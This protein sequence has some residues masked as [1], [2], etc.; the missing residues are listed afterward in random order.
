MTGMRRWW[1][2][3][4]CLGCGTAAGL[5]AGY[6]AVTG[7]GPL[8]AAS[9][10]VIPRGNIAQIGRALRQAGVIARVLPFRLAAEATA[11]QGPLR[12]AEFR[13]PAEASLWDVLL[14]LRSGRPVQH[15]LTIPEGLT[16]AQIVLLFWQDAAL[17]GGIT[18]PKEGSVL[19]QTY[20]FERGATRQSVLGRAQAA[21][22][23][24]VVSAWRERAAEAGVAS[25]RDAII[26]ASIVERE[27]ALA[28]ERPLVARVFRNRLLHGMRLQSDP[29]TIYGASGGYGKL[30]RPLSRADLEADGPYN[31]Y[32]V[33]GLPAAPICNPG[34]ASLSAVLHPAPG[35][36]LYFV[37]D[38]KGGHSFATSL[39]EHEQNVKVYRAQPK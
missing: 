31:T 33:A 5:Y 19:P 24:A 23:D 9:A 6:W 7:R 16:S 34:L 30:D 18:V 3:G 21:M 2:L 29:T 10:V 8:P 37:A 35:S 13:F 14:V 39:S 28:D 15:S 32:V 4:A 1:L 26:L 25:A 12:A 17:T 36:A 20:E 38:G 27:T 22:R 11:W